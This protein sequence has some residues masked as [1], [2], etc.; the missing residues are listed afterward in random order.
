M[1]V[2]HKPECSV[3]PRF[4]IK[5][6]QNKPKLKKK[7]QVLFDKRISEFSAGSLLENMELELTKRRTS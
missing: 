3:Q 6:P 2:Y 5:S 4:P 1:K 7:S